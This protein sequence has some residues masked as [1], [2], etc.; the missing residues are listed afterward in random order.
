MLTVFHMMPL[1]FLA[2][3][4]KAH[5]YLYANVGFSVSGHTNPTKSFGTDIFLLIFPKPNY[6]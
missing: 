2:G 6:G 3:Y 4:C 1:Y 5:L